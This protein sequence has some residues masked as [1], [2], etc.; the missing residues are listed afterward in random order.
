MHP[1]H[2]VQLMTMGHESLSTVT[3]VALLLLV[4]ILMGIARSFQTEFT[5]VVFC[6]YKQV[7]MVDVT[8]KNTDP[9]IYWKVA[10]EDLGIDKDKIKRLLLDSLASKE[11][12]KWCL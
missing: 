5:G 2:F 4:N 10:H 6:E 9:L 12:E 8:N 1:I 3:V 11:N 7:C